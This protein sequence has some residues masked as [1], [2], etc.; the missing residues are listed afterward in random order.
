VSDILDA[1]RWRY[2]VKQFDAG[3]KIPAATW[4]Q[5][6]EALVLSPSSYGLQPWKFFVVDTP[7]V[8]E[9]L[10]PFS[11][12]QKQIVDAS[13]LV[14]FAVKKNVGPADAERLIARITEVRGIPAAALEVYKGMMTGSLS[15][16]SPEAIEAWMS[17]QCFIALG[18]FLVACAALGVDACPME[19]FQPEKYDEILGLTVKGYGS[20]VVAT[21]GYRASS[22]AYAALK[23]VRYPVAEMVEHL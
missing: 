23:K 5:L 12:G 3:K 7:G 15:R 18:Q 9:Q 8:R 16:Q 6:E 20:I 22:D 1:L 10:L 17:R 2:A 19:G 11:W 14:V 4:S 13:H 21:A